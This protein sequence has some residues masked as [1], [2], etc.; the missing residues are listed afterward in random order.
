[1]LWAVIAKCT[2]KNNG[3]YED[4]ERVIAQFDDPFHAEDFINKCLPAENRDRFYIRA[5]TKA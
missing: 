1:M 4:F 2:A 3:K 5:N